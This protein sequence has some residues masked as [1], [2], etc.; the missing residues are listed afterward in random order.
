VKADAQLIARAIERGLI[1]LATPAPV[2]VK[3]RV[4]KNLSPQ[5]HARPALKV[6]CPRFNFARPAATQSTSSGIARSQRSRIPPPLH[7]NLEGHA[8]KIPR[9]GPVW[10]LIIGIPLL[11]LCSVGLI[12]CLTRFTWLED[13]CARWVEELHRG[14]ANEGKQ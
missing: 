10:F 4:I 11:V 12:C 1:K 6:V 7:A 9:T 3:V 13:V 14:G 8:V 5:L 2:K